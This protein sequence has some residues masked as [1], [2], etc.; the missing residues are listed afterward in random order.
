MFGV[1]Y[2]EVTSEA[3][4]KHIGAGGPGGGEVKMLNAI[5]EPLTK[6]VVQV[7]T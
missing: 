4:T 6:L 3:A 7:S 1:G 5:T 2:L